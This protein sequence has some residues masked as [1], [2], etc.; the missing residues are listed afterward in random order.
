MACGH[1]VDG[2]GTA[3]GRPEAAVHRLPLTSP[4]LRPPSRRGGAVAAC[5]KGSTTK[6]GMIELRDA[7]PDRVLSQLGRAAPVTCCP[8]WDK[9][10]Q[11]ILW[12]A[13]SIPLRW[14]SCVLLA[15]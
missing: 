13:S 2:C 11:A 14:R 10:G 15:N 4:T 6:E 12:L 9:A 8:N 3:R 1:R 5:G 7:T